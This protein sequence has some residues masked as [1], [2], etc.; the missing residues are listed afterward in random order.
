MKLQFQKRST[1]E[2][3]SLIIPHAWR[4]GANNRT[5]SYKKNILENQGAD[6]NY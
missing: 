4:V 3:V 6:P 5:K 1:L 2:L